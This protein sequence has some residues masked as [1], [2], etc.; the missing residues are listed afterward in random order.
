[1]LELGFSRGWVAGSLARVCDS[2]LR[3]QL[4]SGTVPRA[5][6]R[7]MLLMGSAEA[8]WSRLLGPRRPVK[9]PTRSKQ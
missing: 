7:R 1:M 5:A 8:A 4:V 6:L 3:C 9:L 2:Q